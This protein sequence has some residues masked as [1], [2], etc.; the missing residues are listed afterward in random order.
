MERAVDLNQQAEDVHLAELVLP[1]GP[2]SSWFGSRW[3]TVLGAGLIVAAGLAV[4]ANSF[5]VPFIFDDPLSIIDNPSIRQ[6][7]PPGPALSPP[8]DNRTVTS[9]PLLNF[10]LAINYR[11]G[12]LNVWGYHAANVAI[13]LINGLLLLGILR[14]TFQLPTLRGRF[15]EAGWGLALAIALLWTI[16]PLQTE[17]V[18]YVIQRAESLAGLFY[19]LTLYSVIRGSQSS[20]R[21]WWYAVAVGA[22][23]LGVGCK[24]IVSTAPIVVL[25]YDRTFLGDS[26]RNLL[27]RRWALYAG[28]FACWGFQLFLLARTGLSML[29]EEVGTIG[30]WAYARSQPG[31]IL[32]YL[33]LSFWPHPL[34]LDYEWPVA[35]TLGAIL[36]GVLVVG[37]IGAATIW[38]L[39]RQRGWG[40]LGAWFFLILAPTS[41]IMPLPQLAF[42]HRMYLPLAAVLTLAITGGYLAVQRVT[43]R[44]WISSYVGIAGGIGLVV[45]A[46]VVL[47]WLTFHRNQVYQDKRSI[48]E[49][50]VAKSPHNARAH[51]NLGVVLTV[52]GEIPESIEH[53][54]AALRYDPE[55]M[56]AYNNL[57]L[58]LTHADRWSEAI[59][60]YQRAVKLKPNYA[61]ARMNMGLALEH[62]GRLT[63]AVEQH[64]EAI[65][66]K[67]Q[68]AAAHFNFGNSLSQLGRMAEAMEQFEQALQIKPDYAEAHNNWGNLLLR[69]GRQAEAAEHYQRAIDGDPSDP[70]YHTNL[71]AA[72]ADL[73][74]LPEAVEQ[75]REALRIAPTFAQGHV[76]LCIFLVKMGK[77]REAIEHGLEVVRL[78]PNDPRINCYVARLLATQESADGGDPARAVEL[79]ERTC[80]LTGRRD[81][82]CLDVLAAAYASAG[83]FDKAVST[84]KEAWQKAQ[85]AGQSALAAELHIR[86]QLYR[87]GK[88]YREPAVTPAGRRP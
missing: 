48:W 43:S 67:P 4:Y 64:Q 8:C 1:G 79:V 69:Q 40:F 53:F 37:G 22:C 56:I 17:A 49:D 2:K 35:D 74:R 80:A 88:P 85:A 12:G 50:T 31:V 44:R 32:H 42:E 78:V 60:Q 15:G 16:H 7:W 57:G 47:G 19:L 5:C 34:C 86:L 65:R 77:F 24:E 39:T 20:R 33:G 73:G 10:S 14:Q 61:E 58:S 30:M 23:F 66:L 6:L 81:I 25:F 68:S 54:R 55:Y 70:M 63:E 72:L 51:S 21:A 26:F 28:L 46:A 27:R 76:S 71:G 84:A 75:S 18:T 29:K 52:E 87:D 9:R 45:L 38:G 41:S 83:R 59:E 36:P 3:A 62:V 82:V 11:L 13:H